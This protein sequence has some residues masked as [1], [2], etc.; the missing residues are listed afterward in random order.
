MAFK[1]SSLFH[2][3]IKNVFIYET[4]TTMQTLLERVTNFLGFEF[5]FERFTEKAIALIVKPVLF[6]EIIKFRIDLCRICSL[7]PQTLSEH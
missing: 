6:I 7:Y 4:K 2:V 1:I 5:G 3:A